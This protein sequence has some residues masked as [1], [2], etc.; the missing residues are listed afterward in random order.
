MPL[1]NIVIPGSSQTTTQ[2]DAT[3][4]TKQGISTPIVAPT[5]ANTATAASTHEMFIAVAVLLAVGM[6]L[7]LVAG[8]SDSA[9]NAIIA[10]LCIIVFIQL[11]TKVNPFI[12]WI[13]THPLTPAG[14]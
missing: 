6:V 13:T 9:A 8:E 2:A 10:A 11:V 14:S 7:T 4:S 5:A 12:S 3:A 1:S